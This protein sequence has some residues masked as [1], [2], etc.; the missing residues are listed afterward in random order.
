VG[1][2]INITSS[3]SGHVNL[4]PVVQGDNNRVEASVSISI[5]DAALERAQAQLAQLAP[6]GAN[7]AVVSEQ[8]KAL[9]EEA[10]QPARSEEKGSRILKVIRDNFSWAYT[11]VKDLV[12]VIWPALVHL[13]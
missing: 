10:K 7:S 3:G 5:I 12:P 11:V 9:A 6:P 1:N 13:L 8:L 2:K 4:G